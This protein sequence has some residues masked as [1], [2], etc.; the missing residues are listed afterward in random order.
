MKAFEFRTSLYNHKKGGE[1][2][3]KITFSSVS[4]MDWCFGLGGC[5]VVKIN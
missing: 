1:N 4:P 2:M 3:S 5:G